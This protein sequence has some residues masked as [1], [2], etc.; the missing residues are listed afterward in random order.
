M[1]AA[2]KL[3]SDEKWAGDEA[4]RGLLLNKNV[5]LLAYEAYIKDHHEQRA[6]LLSIA[7]K[8]A[9]ESSADVSSKVQLMHEVAVLK[10]QLAARPIAP[11]PLALAE[12]AQSAAAAAAAPA[13]PDPSD[14]RLEAM[15]AA[16]RLAL[17]EAVLARGDSEAA[18]QSLAAERADRAAEVGRLRAEIDRLRAEIER[19]RA[20]RAASTA[21]AAAA[22][23]DTKRQLEA[24]FCAESRAAA[25]ATAAAAAA[26]AADADAALA[27]ERQRTAIALERFEA[28]DCRRMQLIE[29]VATLRGSVRVLARVRPHIERELAGASSSAV[30]A[31]PPLFRFP[32]ASTECTELEVVERAG[33]GVG[34]YGKADTGKTT[35]FAFQRVFAPTATQD[36]VFDEVE[37]LVHSALNGHRSTCLAYGQTGSGKTHTMQGGPGESAGLIPRSIA[38]LFDRAA[39][40]RAKGWKIECSVECFEIHLEAMRDLLIAPGASSAALEIKHSAKGGAYVDKLSTHAV[41]SPGD[42]EQLMARANKLRATS[43]TLM[44]A[45]SSRSHLIFTLRVS[46]S[47]AATAQQR[48]GVLN[49]VDLAGSERL[50]KSGAEGERKR[51]ASAINSSLSA[52]SNVM[53]RKSRR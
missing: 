39:L 20:E 50:D 46:A 53:R 2:K 48:A 5:R 47:H 41:D 9:V 49:L 4:L 18:R 29:Q 37:C 24:R 26:A 32:N 33:A 28:S 43:A 42:I 3:L 15:R 30:A 38:L 35:P 25:E 21:A 12:P 44:N 40:M 27:A 16:E 10:R 7:T 45:N 8:Q 22:L 36:E 51:E 17:D 13:G 1:P 31:E 23:A 52:L 6:D 19:Q 14:A 34:G 11:V